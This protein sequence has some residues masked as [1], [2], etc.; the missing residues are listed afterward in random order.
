MKVMVFC[1]SG[2]FSMTSFETVVLPTAAGPD[3]MNMLDIRNF[4]YLPA[5]ATHSVAGWRNYENS[6]K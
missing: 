2:N 3:R 4:T 1:R 5:I 6:R